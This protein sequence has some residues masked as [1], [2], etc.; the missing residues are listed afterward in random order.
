[1]CHKNMNTCHLKA[2]SNWRI[3]GIVIAL[4]KVLFNIYFGQYFEL[5]LAIVHLPNIYD[6]VIGENDMFS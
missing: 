4:L 3:V 6:I 5:L 1:M 2:D